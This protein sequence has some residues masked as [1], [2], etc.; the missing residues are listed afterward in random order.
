MPMTPHVFSVHCPESMGVQP[1]AEK[2]L[3]S[4]VLRLTV[5]GKGNTTISERSLTLS[6]SH[7]SYLRSSFILALQIF[8]SSTPFLSP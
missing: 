7:L 8:L 4:H 2:A 3:S 1:L 6:L 5:Y